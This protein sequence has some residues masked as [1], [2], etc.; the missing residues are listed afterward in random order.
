[1]IGSIRNLATLG[2][3]YTSVVSPL[4]LVVSY[5]SVLSLHQC[6][7]TTALN[8]LKAVPE[9]LFSPTDAPNRLEPTMPMS[10]V[11]PYTAGLPFLAP[12]IPNEYLQLPLSKEM[13]MWVYRVYFKQGGLTQR[14]RRFHAL[15]QTYDQL[16]EFILYTIRM[17]VR[18]RVIHYLDLALRH[19]S[20]D[21]PAERQPKILCHDRGT[22]IRNGRRLSLIHTSLI[23]TPS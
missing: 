3:L 6:W 8:T 17:D 12:I 9:N 7:F 15:L 13:S 2:N 18:C 1:L 20:L 16:A 19:V 5:L 10:A 14:H 4:I 22:T 11:T 21:F 23:S